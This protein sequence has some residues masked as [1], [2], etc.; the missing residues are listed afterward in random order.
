MSQSLTH[1]F[2]NRVEKFFWLPKPAKRDITVLAI[3]PHPE[4]QSTVLNIF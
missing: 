3:E 1:Q 2:L 4:D